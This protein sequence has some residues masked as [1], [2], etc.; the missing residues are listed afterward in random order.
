[1]CAMIYKHKPM[2][3]ALVA[4]GIIFLLGMAWMLSLQPRVQS[5]EAE[6]SSV[7]MAGGLTCTVAGSL[8]I[9]AFS[10]YKFTHL[11]K[12]TGAR[13]SDKYKNKH[14]KKNRKH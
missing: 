5:G 1:M 13:H 11:W 8:L 7:L 10:R 2:L 3:P 6:P 9:M 14:K 4:A 12:S